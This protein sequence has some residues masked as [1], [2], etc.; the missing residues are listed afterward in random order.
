MA[1]PSP[2]VPECAFLGGSASGV[3]VEQ[4]NTKWSLRALKAIVST[5]ACL[6]SLPL[7]LLILILCCCHPPPNFVENGAAASPPPSPPS[8]PPSSPHHD[9]RLDTPLPPHPP[10]PTKPA[11]P[12]PVHQSLPSSPFRKCVD[13]DDA[14]LAASAPS[15]PR[16]GRTLAGFV[17][18]WGEPRAS[19]R[20]AFSPRRQHR[21]VFTPYAGTDTRRGGGDGDGRRARSRV[22]WRWEPTDTAEAGGGGGVDTAGL[23]HGDGLPTVPGRDGARHLRTVASEPVFEEPNWLIRSWGAEPGRLAE[24]GRFADRVGEAHAEAE[25]G[26]RRPNG[27]RGAYADGARAPAAVRGR[28]LRGT[29]ARALELDGAANGGDGGDGGDG[30]R[31]G[32]RG[33]DRECCAE[34]R[35]LLAAEMHVVIAK[36]V[37]A[38]RKAQAEAAENARMLEW[39]ENQRKPRHGEA[40]GDDVKV[41]NKLMDVLRSAPPAG[42]AGH[43][44]PPKPSSDAGTSPRH[45]GQPPRAFKRSETA[46]GSGARWQRA[47]GRTAAHRPSKH[48]SPANSRSG[49]QLK[50]GV[51]SHSI[52]VTMRG[53]GAAD[54]AGAANAPANGTP[55]GGDEEEGGWAAIHGS[56][57]GAAPS[58]PRRRAA[59]SGTACRTVAV[60]AP[61]AAPSAASETTERP[62]RRRERSNRRGHATKG[63]QVDPM[64][65]R[66]A[67]GRWSRA[68]HDELDAVGGRGR[69]LTPYI[70]LRWRTPTALGVGALAALQMCIIVLAVLVVVA[71]L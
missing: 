35:E 14:W 68:Y 2:A 43:T 67:P 58:Q 17:G 32:G 27:R 1:P 23:R 69:A 40:E 12:L 13:A 26:E 49:A 44:Q 53:R 30:G 41:E 22:E 28:H 33:T 54:R 65:K 18:F 29:R 70:P 46:E 3:V 21:W 16:H 25:Q 8:S 9:R 6:A 11:P 52:G 5:I 31:R 66:L 37:G 55:S 47:V 39:H 57:D 71:G 42:V 7:L 59:K 45:N 64:P 10:S 61:S 24:P 38:V 62:S 63:H 4:R 36:L 20:T 50:D 56:G 60:S 51:S 19:R 15:S 34:E 48:A